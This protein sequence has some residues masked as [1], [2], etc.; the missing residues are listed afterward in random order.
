MLEYQ[1]NTNYCNEGFQRNIVK[2]NRL[3]FVVTLQNS[4]FTQESRE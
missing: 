3:Y 1:K 2:D 4:Q